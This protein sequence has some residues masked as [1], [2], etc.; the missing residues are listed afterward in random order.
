MIRRFLGVDILSTDFGGGYFRMDGTSMSAA[1]LSG[2]AALVVGSRRLAGLTVNVT[3]VRARLAETAVPAALP[4]PRH[5]EKV[6]HAGG[7]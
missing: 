7:L 5:P 2:A 1:H 3:E 6:V 4:H